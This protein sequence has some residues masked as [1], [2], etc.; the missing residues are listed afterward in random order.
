MQ[1]RSIFIVEPVS[2]IERQE[3]DLGSFRQIGGLID[4]KATVLHSSLQC[5]AITVAPEHAVQQ[6]ARRLS[7]IRGAATGR[8]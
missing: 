8:A 5:H 2:R 7:A 3:F 4:H 6:S 1:R